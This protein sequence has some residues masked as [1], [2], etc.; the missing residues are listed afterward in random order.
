MIASVLF[1][2]TLTSVYLANNYT[3]FSHV[4]N[5]L[6]GLKESFRIMSINCHNFVF[7][8]TLPLYPR[9]NSEIIEAI[10]GKSSSNVSN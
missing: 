5:N 10:T 4:K 8:E 6:L 3:F 2:S 7:D 9:S 1:T